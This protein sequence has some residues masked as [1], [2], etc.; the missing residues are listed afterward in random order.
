MILNYEHKLLTEWIELNHSKYAEG[1][2]EKGEGSGYIN[3]SWKPELITPFIK[4]II[5]K[6]VL[7]KGA[8]ILDFGCAKGFYVKILQNMGYDAIGIDVSEYALSKSPEDLRNRLFLLKDS[9]LELFEPNYFNL[10]ISKDVLEHVPEFALRYLIRELK[11]I[12]K[13]LF[14]TVPF[15]DENRKY[16]NRGDEFDKTHQIR[17]TLSEWLELLDNVVV[18]PGLCK[19]IKHDKSKGTL[20]C[21]LNNDEFV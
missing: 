14:L 21:F 7:E 6:C 11:R 16:I 4:G 1:Y 20:C 12:S 8:R 9:P 10:I 15:C 19:L 17:Y 18:E 3:Y 2:F 13:K 5:E